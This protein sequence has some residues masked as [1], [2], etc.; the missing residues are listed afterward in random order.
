MR[1]SPPIRLAAHAAPPA[2]RDPWLLLGDGVVRWDL[3]GGRLVG[4]LRIQAVELIDGRVGQ[5]EDLGVSLVLA[6]A[7]QFLGDPPRIA[8]VLGNDLLGRD[9]L[10]RD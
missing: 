7:Q 10:Q 3:I 2:P 1:R 9:L 6:A 4:E 5:R 8:R